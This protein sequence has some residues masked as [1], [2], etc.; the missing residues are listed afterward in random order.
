METLQ[1]L[2]KTK[3]VLESLKWRL[4]TFEHSNRPVHGH[5]ILN[6]KLKIHEKKMEVLSLEGTWMCEKDNH[7]L[8]RRCLFLRLLEE[9][10]KTKRD[11]DN[12]VIIGNELD[13]LYSKNIW[14]YRK[15]CKLH[16]RTLPC[17]FA[18]NLLENG[19]SQIEEEG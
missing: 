2:T 18:Q 7:R 9:E 16:R 1:R 11:W 8:L 14:M 13:E 12:L 6:L 15:G 3:S 10:T 4:F 19:V 5:I 17:W